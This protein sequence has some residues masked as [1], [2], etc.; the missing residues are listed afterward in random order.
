LPRST[1][2]S[3]DHGGRPHV[4]MAV[5]NFIVGDS[6]VQK[7]ARSMHEH[8]WRVTLVG[9]RLNADDPEQGE[10]DGVPAR[11]VHITSRTGS[12]PE[13]ERSTL[14]RSPLAYTTMRKQRFADGMADAALSS[15]R[16]RIDD[17][18][19]RGRDHGARWLA[20]RSPLALALARRWLVDR[21]VQASERLRDRRRRAI[22]LPDRIASRWWRLIRRGDAWQ[23]LDPSIWDWVD[24][25]LPV[26]ERLQPDL[27]HANDHRML[28]V[29]ARAKLR[30]AVQGRSIKVVWDAHEWLAGMPVSPAMS[31]NWLPAQ[32][33][34][35]RRHARY[36]DAVITVSDVLADMLHHHHRLSRTPEVVLNAPL[37]VGISE[38]KR[39]L[40]EVVGLSPEEPL[41]VYAGSLSGQRSVETVVR[42]L[43]ELPKVHFAMVVSNHE[44]PIVRKTVKLAEQLGV[45]HR[46]HLA[47]YVAVEQIVPYLASADVGIHPIMHGPN[48]EIALATKYYEYAQARLPILVTDVKVMAETTRR[49]GQGEIFAAGDSQDLVR[50]A[51]LLFGDLERYR[52]AFDDPA[53][54]TS[55]TWETQAE[56]LDQ[57]YRRT[58]G[59]GP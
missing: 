35:E 40:R 5:D 41:L 2:A 52:K 49:T 34:V 23:R 58:L 26:L 4:V 11:F 24:A 56:I 10:F 33:S 6:R 51:R 45:A 54:M 36:A 3:P 38:P 32:L 37:T 7:E 13:L 53:L 39:T 50:A 27:V 59:T 20:S 8:G 22:G 25:Y 44:H 28:H 16:M 19:V 12:R 30:A 43:P 47:P 21:R 46:L 9:R 18:K 17:L 15:S 48:T 29:A 42:A 31:R 57:V 14:I 55:W 1:N